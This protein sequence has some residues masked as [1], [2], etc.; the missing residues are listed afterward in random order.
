VTTFDGIRAAPTHRSGSCSHRQLQE[1][2]MAEHPH[3][4]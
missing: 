4:H 1:D 2:T 3:Q